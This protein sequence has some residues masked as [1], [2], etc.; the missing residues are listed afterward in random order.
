MYE[1]ISSKEK[2]IM[3]KILINIDVEKMQ[4]KNLEKT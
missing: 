4:K 2:K 1:K 3:K